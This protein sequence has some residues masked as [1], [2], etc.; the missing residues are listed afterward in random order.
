VLK[1]RLPTGA[2]LIA[3][4]LLV[5]WLDGR[6]EV[7]WSVQGIVLAFV[8]T[9]IVV[10]AGI[11]LAGLC[12]GAGV[13]MSASMGGAS[14]FVGFAVGSAAALSHRQG[15]SLAG[16]IL[17]LGIAGWL[18]ASLIWSARHRRTDGA[19][20]SIAG[21]M[22]LF[23]YLGVIPAQYLAIR[24]RETAWTVI[25]IIL[26]V[27]SCDIG[28]YFVGSAIGKRKLI[29]W[30]SPGKTW[31]GLLGGIATSAL[32]AALIAWL[33]CNTK[34]G[35]SL[36]FPVTPIVAAGIGAVLAVIG[37]AGDLAVSLFKRDAGV[38]DTAAIIPGMIFVAP[39]ASWIFIVLHT[40]K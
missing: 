22:L 21:A 5:G 16:V 29:P 25:A 7:L 2:V 24:Q 40:V 13:K 23:L 3:L 1:H 6:A 18:A 8:M 10:L 39:A 4:M 26:I 28:A 32:L 37:Q 38:K 31:E 19:M 12:C 34:L 9:P 20:L 17:P 33:S 15:L 27:K 14:A 30:L 35:V 36:A 11:E